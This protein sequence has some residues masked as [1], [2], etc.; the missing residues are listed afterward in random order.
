MVLPYSNVCKRCRQ[1]GKQDQ[2]APSRAV[3][4]GCTLFAKTCL[5][6]N[7]RSL[8]YVHMMVF[9]QSDQRL[10]CSLLRQEAAK[11]GFLVTWLK[12][13]LIWVYTVC[14]DLSVHKLIITL[15][16][17]DGIY[18]KYW[19]SWNE[20]HHEK[21]CFAI[22]EQQRRRSACAFTA[23]IVR[24]LDRI[25]PLVSTFKIS[26]LYTRRKRSTC[27]PLAYYRR[28]SWPVPEDYLTCVNSRQV[29]TEHKG[30]FIQRE[31]IYLLYI[32]LKIGECHMLR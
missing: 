1:N 24:C 2:T 27:T 10:C 20:P 17:H 19:N 15:C 22:C 23:F 14:Q 8:R 11:T 28:M 9:A 18:P 29:T 5:S 13:S 16:S 7:L 3:W 30:H 21:T 6:T 31:F 32:L 26:S 4:S 25:I 12:S